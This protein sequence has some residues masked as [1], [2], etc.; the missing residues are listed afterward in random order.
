MSRKRKGI[1]ENE[2]DSRIR[3]MIGER[4]KRARER[5]GLSALTLG[6][7]VGVSRSAITQI[8]TSRNN[9]S[10]TLLW[11]I[12]CAL[13][14]SITDFFPEVPESSSLLQSDI[15]RIA[16]ENVEAAHLMKKAG[17]IKKKREKV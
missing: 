16:A 13:H 12:A 10:A 11:R 5:K 6:E 3:I 15:D 4:I 8:E 1:I 9:V 2:A 7:S 14:C 17:F